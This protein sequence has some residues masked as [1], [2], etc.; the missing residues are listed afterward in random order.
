[1]QVKYFCLKL[2]AYINLKAPSR[3]EC[4]CYSERFI[5]LVTLIYSVMVCQQLYYKDRLLFQHHAVDS[6][7]SNSAVK[8]FSRHL[9]Y[10]PLEM[11]PHSLFSCKLN[12]VEKL[13]LADCLLDL[14]PKESIPFP[15]RQNSTGHG[16]PSFTEKYWQ[17]PYFGTLGYLYSLKQWSFLSGWRCSKL[18]RP[19]SISITMLFSKIDAHNMYWTWC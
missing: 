6:S 16:K 7:F 13:E 14:K 5:L 3:Q 17:L 11:F 19:T 12:E 4:G 8:A 10:L 18:V 1:M 9:W 15:Q 2:G